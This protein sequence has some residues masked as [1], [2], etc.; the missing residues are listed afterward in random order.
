MELLACPKCGSQWFV[1]SRTGD[2]IVFQVD[3]KH[4][5]II[6]E[7]HGVSPQAVPIDPARIF[8]GACSWQGPV[9]DLVESR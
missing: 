4:H 8:C 6:A 3:E 1:S 9:T 5:P 7:S 2:R